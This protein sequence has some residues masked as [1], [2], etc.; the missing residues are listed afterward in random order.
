MSDDQ[1]AAAKDRLFGELDWDGPVYEVSA[2]TGEGTV[3]L[4]Q[5]V[6]QFLERLMEAS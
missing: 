2:V 5:A 6:V 4:G 1:L 3:A